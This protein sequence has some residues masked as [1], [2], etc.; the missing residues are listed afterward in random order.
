M[1]NPAIQQHHVRGCFEPC[2][3]AA[4]KLDRVKMTY[5]LEIRLGPSGVVV[6]AVTVRSWG[7]FAHG[8]HDGDGRYSNTLTQEPFPPCTTYKPIFCIYRR[9]ANRWASVSTSSMKYNVWAEQHL[10]MWTDWKY[11]IEGKLHTLRGETLMVWLITVKNK[12]WKTEIHSLHFIYRLMTGHMCSACGHILLLFKKK[13]CVSLISDFTQYVRA[14]ASEKPWAKTGV[15]V[16]LHLHYRCVGSL[17][18]S[19]TP[20]R[21]TL[22]LSWDQIQTF[23]RKCYEPLQKNLKRVPFF[24]TGFQWRRIRIK[25]AQCRCMSVRKAAPGA[26]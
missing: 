25:L 3:I 15:C 18:Y 9:A 6:W 14:E 13:T 8:F 16:I 26:V 4:L 23:G 1:R 11:L 24:I 10:W 21:G 22:A 5:F 12:T 19:S 2:F 20:Q 7:V 17:S